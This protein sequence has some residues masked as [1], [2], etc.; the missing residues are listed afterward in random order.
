MKMKL[1]VWSLCWSACQAAV[2]A[3]DGRIPITGPMAITEPGSYVLLNDVGNNFTGAI[4]IASSD[5]TL[6]LN[7]FTVRLTQVSSAFADGIS[8]G[9]GLKNIE[10]KN[11]AIT[12]FPRNGIY[13]PGE[14]TVGRNLRFSHLRISNCGGWA[15]SLEQ[16]PGF[17]IE[18]SLLT[19]NKLGIAAGGAGLIVNNVIGNNTVR[20]LASNGAQL[21][22]RSN[23]FY[24][25]G[26]D[27]TGSATNLGSNL[28]SG[29]PCP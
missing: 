4:R 11:G 14:A 3:G 28:C 18:D 5:V 19:A 16:N 26:I 2:A 23:V 9:H 25:N 6:D 21:G 12:G 29:A 1:L 10:V 15:I 8:I 13:A 24:S 22:Y 20:G 17:I 7:G 27:V